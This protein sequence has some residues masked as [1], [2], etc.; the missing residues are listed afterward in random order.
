MSTASTKISEEDPGRTPTQAKPT[1]SRTASV[2]PKQ[3]H[4][5]G[6]EALEAVNGLYQKLKDSQDE[7]EQL[8]QE[9]RDL[10]K[11]VQDYKKQVRT[12]QAELQTEKEKYKA[13]QMVQDKINQAAHKTAEEKLSTVLA[14]LRNFSSAAYKLMP[15]LDVLTDAPDIQYDESTERLYEIMKQ[16]NEQ[17]GHGKFLDSKT[18]HSR[19]RE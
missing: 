17:S 8:R 12:L 15:L 6:F 13:A 7:N 5:P 4:L 3:F 2:E 1:Q 11:E 10:T 9:N 19:S 16:H 18:E 14:S